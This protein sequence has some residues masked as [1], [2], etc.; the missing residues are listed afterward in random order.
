[1]SEYESERMLV[2]K[3]V[4]MTLDSA[5]CEGVCDHCGFNKYENERRRGLPLVLDDDGL[6]RKHVGQRQ[7]AKEKNG[8]CQ[9]EKET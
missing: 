5:L 6:R 1:M 3:L 2:R 4:C 7:K 9:E 8:I